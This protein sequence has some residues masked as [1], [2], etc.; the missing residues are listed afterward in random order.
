[1]HM[2]RDAKS[3]LLPIYLYHCAAADQPPP[4]PG[5]QLSPAPREVRL[6]CTASPWLFCSLPDLTAPRQGA[7]GCQGAGLLSPA[8]DTGEEYEER[9]CA[10]CSPPAETCVGGSHVLQSLHRFGRHRQS[11]SDISCMRHPQSCTRLSSG[12]DRTL[13]LCP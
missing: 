10:G 4:R 5:R 1:M 13:P 3:N 11:S 9:L 2:L 8:G 7:E 6:F 12:Q